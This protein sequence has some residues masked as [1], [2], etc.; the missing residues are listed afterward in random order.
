MTVTDVDVVDVRVSFQ[1]EEEANEVRSREQEG[2]C[3]HQGSAGQDAWRHQGLQTKT[4]M[5]PLCWLG[6]GT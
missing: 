5:A 4:P 1:G 6:D 3:V 2:H